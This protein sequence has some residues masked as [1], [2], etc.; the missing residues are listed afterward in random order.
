MRIRTN[1][2]K[3]GS[4]L[5]WTVLLIAILSLVAAELLHV[6]STKYNSTLHTAVWQEALLAAE[7]GVDLAVMELRKSLY[8]PPNN[9]W[10][11][12]EAGQNGVTYGLTTIPNAGLAGTPM[13]ISVAVDAPA[14]LRDPTNSWQY[15]RIRTTGTM[16]ITGPAR[17]SDNKQ[18]NHLRKLDLRWDRFSTNAATAAVSAP[19]VSRRVEAIVRPT[20]AFDQA[21]FAV[22]SL[23]LNDLDIIVDSYDSR[24]TAKSTNGLYDVAKR[25]ENGNIASNGQLI[26]AGNAH[27][28]GDVST[29]S[30]TATGV[31][32]VTGV[33]R[34]DFYQEPIPVGAPNWPS[35]NPQP[36]II[37]N[38]TTL[39]G[40][41]TEGSAASRYMVSS[42]VLSGNQDLVFTGA[43]D[44]STRYVE[45]YVTGDIDV[46]GNGQIRTGPAL[47]RAVC[48][49]NPRRAHALPAAPGPVPRRGRGGTRY[50]CPSRRRR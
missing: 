46:T 17:A 49:R 28:F 5:I 25:Q 22:G 29:N 3:A 44:G 11:G 40:S 2:K 23:N 38:N 47:H 13:T 7:S 45:L 41:P 48:P 20:S 36:M 33:I 39:A 26:N 32:N 42:V 34:D 21:I 12:W 27:V 18:D 50:W 1:S 6:V 19:R 37:N 43:P 4:A 35:I 24:D 8:P 31:E 9:A 15:Y 14:A 16:P 30:G 10:S